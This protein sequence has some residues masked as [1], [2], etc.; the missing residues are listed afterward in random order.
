MFDYGAIGTAII[1]LESARREQEFSATPVPRR[2]RKARG[3]A[4]RSAVAGAFRGLADTLEASRRT[5]RPG[6]A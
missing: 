1:G 6:R 2:Q 3:M 4:I 5:T